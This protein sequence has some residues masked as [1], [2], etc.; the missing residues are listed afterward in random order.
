MKSNRAGGGWSGRCQLLWVPDQARYEEMHVG[1]GKIQL[2]LQKHLPSCLWYMT[3]ARDFF[4]LLVLE[5]QALTGLVMREG[6]KGRR[7]DVWQARQQER[8]RR[9]EGLHGL[10]VAHKGTCAGLRSVTAMSH[11]LTGCSSPRIDADGFTPESKLCSRNWIFT[12][13]AYSSAVAQPR[14]RWSLQ[15]C[16][17]QCARSSCQRHLK[18]TRN[19]LPC[20]LLFKTSPMDM[21]TKGVGT[22]GPGTVSEVLW[23][24]NHLPVRTLC[25]LEPSCLVNHI[26]AL[27][28]YF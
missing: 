25:K 20:H 22:V 6:E 24:C 19:V 16:G 10:S 1:V 21:A 8:G 2:L 11:F 7:G 27:K 18:F 3:A 9:D 28:K 4:L 15:G 13:V 17:V 12:F 26:F 23:P 14:G 5:M